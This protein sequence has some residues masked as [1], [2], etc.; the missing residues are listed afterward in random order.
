MNLLHGELI[1]LAAPNP[2]ADAETIARWTRDTEYARLLDSDPVTAIRAQTVRDFMSKSEPDRF[3][4]HVRTLA[5]DKL[6]GFAGLSVQWASRDAWFFIGLGERDYW[7]KG[8]GTDAVRAV[9]RYAFTE[10][11]LERVTLNVFD[12]N[13]RARRSYEKAG[14]VYEGAERGL[15]HRD[16]ERW[17]VTFMGILKDEWE[18]ESEP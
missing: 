10:L 2:D 3:I 15:L 14:F 18:K 8:Y 1:R 4:F 7:S 16:G 5:D 11:N 6:I 13:P 9:L 17:G 12:Y